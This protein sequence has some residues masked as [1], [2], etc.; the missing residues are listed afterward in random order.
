MAGTPTAKPYTATFTPTITPTH[1]ATITPTFT[2]TPFVSGLF[3]SIS[4]IWPK[5]DAPTVSGVMWGAV[6]D[7]GLVCPAEWPI[8]SIVLLDTQVEYICVDRYK[9]A[10]CKDNI[11]TALLFTQQKISAVPHKAIITAGVAKPK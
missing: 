10:K 6:V 4:A 3:I 11:C 1:T 5:R 9:T 2:G 8:G 7:K